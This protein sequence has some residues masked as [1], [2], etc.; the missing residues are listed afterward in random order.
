MSARRLFYPA[1]AAISAIALVSL[2]LLAARGDGIPPPS[3][4]VGRAKASR[5]KLADDIRNNTL[6]FEK[7]FVVGLPSRTDRRDGIVLE[8]A[9]SNLDVEFVDGVRGGDVPDKAVPTGP[10]RERL[11][12]PVVGCWRAHMNAMQE[13]VRRN[14]SS[15]LIMEDDADWDVRLRSQ[16]HDFALASH[17]LTQPLAG[18]SPASLRYADATFPDPTDGPSAVPDL[19]FDTL[20]ATAPPTASPYGDHWDV[21]WLGHC[22]MRFPFAGGNGSQA[23]PVPRGRVVH[24]P[25]ATVPQHR[26]LWTMASPDDL[27]AQYGH[28]TRV[29]HHAQDGV[30]T[31]A[32]A[33]TRRGA[34]KLLRELGLEA[35]GA[36]LDIELRRFCETPPRGGRRIRSCLTAQPS[37]FGIHLPAGPKKSNS[38]ISDHGAGYQAAMTRGVRYS[39]RMN[40]DVLIEGRMNELVDQWPDAGQ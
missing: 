17:A 34:R 15:A 13:V 9:L 33:V 4:G 35:L 3:L 23:A 32:Y 20:P 24:A 6:G 22:G 7:I 37:L 36:P 14:L 19:A 1:L 16:L 31:L 27:R 38:D 29:V 26:H 5:P 18:S 10:G 8:A 40:A 21:L 39:V 2:Y 12:D 11:P 30:C 25:D 28:H